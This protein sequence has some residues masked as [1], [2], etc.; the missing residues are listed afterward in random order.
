MTSDFFVRNPDV[1]VGNHSKSNWVSV[2]G[3]C[4]YRDR[5]EQGALK[6]LPR[7]H[8]ISRVN[9]NQVEA[10]IVAHF[11]NTFGTKLFERLGNLDATK[12]R[13]SLFRC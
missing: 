11:Q 5:T 1:D 4:T 8:A 6:E 2:R 9:S 10:Y 3:V 13:D 12:V 7:S